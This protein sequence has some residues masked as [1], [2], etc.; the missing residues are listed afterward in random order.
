MSVFADVRIVLSFSGSDFWFVQTYPCNC[1]M[2]LTPLYSCNNTVLVLKNAS[3][4]KYLKSLLFLSYRCNILYYCDSEVNSRHTD[5]WDMFAIVVSRFANRLVP[6][7]TQ[8]ASDL[9]GI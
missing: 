8:G 3:N 5:V 9:R 1:D 2:Q 7:V 4:L 6:I